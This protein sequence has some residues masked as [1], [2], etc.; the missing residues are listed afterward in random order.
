MHTTAI[1]PHIPAPQRQ[2]RRSISKRRHKP[3]AIGYQFDIETMC[4][5]SI[6]VP[7]VM[8]PERPDDQ[9]RLV[10]LNGHELTLSL[11]VP[12]RVPPRGYGPVWIVFLEEITARMSDPAAKIKK[13]PRQL[14]ITGDVQ[15]VSD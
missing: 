8:L 14:G 6:A 13:T 4:K 2:P 1:F 11:D 5:I 7:L 9:C 10:F 15:G 12:C 3:R